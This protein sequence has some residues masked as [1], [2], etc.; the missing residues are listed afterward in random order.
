MATRDALAPR[1]WVGIAAR[2]H[3]QRGI[4]GGFCQLG[5]GKAA[6]IRRLSPGDGIVYYSPRTALDGGVPVQAFT[7]IGHIAPGEPYEGNMGGGFHPTRRDVIWTIAAHDAPIRPLLG[8][9]SFTRDR[10]NWGMAMRRS[11]F[12]ITA[13][14]FAIIA[15]AMGVTI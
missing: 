13:E 7:G 15:A 5:H 11:S 14:D 1:Y 6:P 8:R 2:D 9:L 10:A 3:V 4:A 12:A